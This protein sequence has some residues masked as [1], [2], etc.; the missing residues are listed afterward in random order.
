MQDGDVRGEM[1]DWTCS[2]GLWIKFPYVFIYQR[3]HA[4]VIAILSLGEEHVEALKT[5]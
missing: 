2:V 1:C 3:S 5:H 4:N